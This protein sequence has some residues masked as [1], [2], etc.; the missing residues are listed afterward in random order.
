MRF[1]VPYC[2]C[3]GPP[4]PG[5]YFH[6]GYVPRERTPI[7]SPKFLVR[8][9]SFFTNLANFFNIPLRNIT[10]LHFFCRSGD[11]NFRNFAAHGRL[12][13]PS[14]ASS[15]RSPALSRVPAR[16]VPTVRSGDPHFSRSSSLSS[17]RSPALSRVPARRV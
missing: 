11:H 6:I 10:I 1:E 9:I 17:L 8:S 16:R 12:T 13:Q 15:L 4:P 2:R 14:S 7:F 5:G 3:P